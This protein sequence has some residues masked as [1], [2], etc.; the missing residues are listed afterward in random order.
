[1]QCS[2]AV[3]SASYRAARPPAVRAAATAPSPTEKSLPLAPRVFTV[4]DIASWDRCSFIYDAT[5]TSGG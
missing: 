5:A 1:M 3:Q 4:T 2:A